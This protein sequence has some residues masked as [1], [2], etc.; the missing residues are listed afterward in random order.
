MIEQILASAFAGLA[1]GICSGLLGIGGGTVMVPIF[2]LAFGMS[3]VASTATSLFTIIPTSISGAVTHVRGK[4][5]IPRLGAAMGLAG[6]LTSPAGVWLAQISPS[7]AVMLVAALIISYSAVKILGK[8]LVTDSRSGRSREDATGRV[9]QP[10]ASAPAGAAAASGLAAEADGGVPLA[11]A[12]TTGAAAATGASAPAGAAAASG[13][14]TEAGGG[15]AEGVAA[16]KLSGRQLA[17]GA[18]IGLGAGLASGY[19]GVGGGFIMVPLM[20][21]F[22]G[23]PLKLASGTSLLAV[24]LLAV[25]GT[26]EQGLLG[27]IDYLAGI[28]VALGS[29]PGAF[30]GARLVSR[31]PERTLRLI[32][33][34]FLLVAV[35]LLVLKETGVLG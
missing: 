2:R 16:P 6:A 20:L 13:L 8:A 5:C 35:L 10:A 33:G 11:A 1:I 3:V 23:I 26:I 34:G 4:T 21:A 24:M 15:A 7:W 31:V 30:I 12:A 18:L 22:L 9:A 14:A 25:P 29:V 27:N 17:L 28:V 32:F 19:V